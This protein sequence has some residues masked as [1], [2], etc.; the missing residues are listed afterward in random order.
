MRC[1]LILGVA[2]CLSSIAYFRSDGLTPNKIASTTAEP[3]VEASLEAKKVLLQP[4]HYLGKGRQ[5]FVF[6]SQDDRYV[7][8]FFNRTYFEMPWYAW[9]FGEK[10][11]F[12][13]EKRRLFFETS[14]PLAWKELGE[15][16]LYVHVG[17]SAD[18]PFIQVVGPASFSF[19]INLNE[20]AFVLQRKGEPFYV[21]LQEIYQKE[22]ILGLKREINAFVSQIQLRIQ[23]QIAD[24]D[25]DVEH[26]WGYIDGKIVHLDP[27]RLYFDPSLG[28]SQ[29]K[30]REWNTATR[31]FFRWLA[32]S[33][34]EVLESN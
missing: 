22:G 28:E 32:K 23:K 33:Y 15:E 2:V 20:T 12:K 21:G 13:R 9:A 1:F 3:S 14:Y 8:K 10:E 5:C 30:E 4:F 26:N 16:I 24:D 29:R 7:L 25:S 27:G 34:P 31:H 17:K 18:L 6:A 19:P 11:R